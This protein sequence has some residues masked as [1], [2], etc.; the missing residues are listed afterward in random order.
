MVSR[1]AGNVRLE[2]YFDAFT[3]P[4]QTRLVVTSI[5]TDPQYLT[6]PVATNRPLQ[7]DCG[8]QGMGS[9]T[10]PRADESR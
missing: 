6:Q 1:T 3:E 4:C 5:V 9:N 2:E 8:W 10:L 7:E